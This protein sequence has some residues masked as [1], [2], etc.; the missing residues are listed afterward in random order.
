M[1]E[2][3]LKCPCYGKV[4][5]LIFLVNFCYLSA[6]ANSHGER[7]IEDVY[8]SLEVSSGIIEDV[9]IEV[10][11]KTGFNFHYSESTVGDQK[12][13]VKM[14]DVSLANCLR[15]ISKETGLSFK[16]INETIHVDKSENTKYDVLEE[17]GEEPK[18]DISVSGR[19]TGGGEGL[20]GVTVIVKGTQIGTVSDID[21]NYTIRVPS[22]ES[23]LVFSFVGFSTKEVVVGSQSEI[24]VSLE[25]DVTALE[26][27]VVIGYG[28]QKK[29]TVVGAVTQASSQVLERTAGIPNVATAL[30]G[31]LPGLITAASSGTPGDSNPRIVIRGNNTWNGTNSPLILVDGVERPEFF[32]NMDVASVAN[33]SV[34]KDASATAVFGSRGANG[35]I[36]VTTK[37][38]R[39]GKAEITANVNTTLKSVSKLPGTK[40]AYDAMQLRNRAIEYELA[41]NP[42]S[43]ADI[44]PQDIINKYRNPAN[45][46]EAER[47]PNIDWQDAL[48][49]DYAMAYNANVGIRG[50]TE[51][52]K[53]FA[54]IDFQNEQD[55]MRDYDNGRG[56]DPGFNYN[57]LNFRS[58]L[59]FQLTNST[60]LQT[61][62]GG[63]YGVRKTPWG[64]GQNDYGYWIAAYGN[65]PDAFIPRYSDGVWGFHAPNRQ[66]AL[67]SVRNL[68]ISG[69]ENRTTAT[70]STNFV[71]DQD[72]SMLVKGL[73]FKGTLALD[74][75]FIES[76]RGAN[77]LYN[78][79]QEKWINPETGVP[80][81][82]QAFDPSTRFDFYDQGAAWSPSAGSI[83]AFNGNAQYR[84]T[85]YQLQLNY[86]TSIVERHNITLMGLMNR[87]QEAYGSAV[88]QY[89][90]DWVFRTTYNFDGKYLLEYNGAYNGSEKFGKDYRFS[91]FSSGGIGWLISEENFMKSIGFLDYLKVRASYGEVGDDGGVPRFA[92]VDD[93]AYGEAAKLGVQGWRSEESPY[94]WYRQTNL[95]NPSVRWE[96]VYKYNL[97]LDFTFWN[98][99]IDG[100]VDFFRD[101]REDIFLSGGGRAVPSYFGAS[102]PAANLGKVTTEGFEIE[103]GSNYT[104]SSGVRIWADFAMTHAKDEV[105]LRDDPQ[106]LDDYQKQIGYQIGQSRTHV[107]SGYYNTW[108]DV[109]A[110]T[111]HNT[112]EASKL[113]G[114]YH[115]IDFNGDGLID[116]LD[117]IPYAFSSTPQNTFNTNIGVEWKGFSA[118]VQFYGVNNVT[119]QV[120]FN[121]LA[122]QLNRAYEEGSYWSKDNTNPDTPMPRWLSIVNGANSGSRYFY[123]GSFL[124]LKNA[125][126]AYRFESGWINKIG[127]Q[128]LRVYLN[129][130]NLLLWTKMPDDRESNFAGTGWAS[131]GAYPTVRR[132][133]LGLNMTF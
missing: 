116:N 131:Q 44:I 82:E 113:P 76:E 28:E 39:E 32:N 79:I 125:E 109:Y 80:F 99:I 6:K 56:Y 35:V 75:T 94:T 100:S 89:R 16:R 127:L 55:L 18:Q 106:L 49:Q 102:A 45:L 129:G 81:Y 110:S 63:S 38:G 128:S 23:V 95:G 7:S 51:V 126:I 86:Q 62:L 46:E 19:V 3:L 24:N 69:V 73:N 54:N 115:I 59:D 91:Y 111:R 98:G 41:T 9:F 88:P 133:S 70:I 71:L 53:Y 48:F 20:P 72:L 119:R 84:K 50:G 132:F 14:Q 5:F 29:E 83:S 47:Y 64:F 57:R 26:E 15:Q 52:T 90:E 8:L 124:R 130:N 118:F 114:N 60:K 34:L 66:A 107:S 27:V 22:R 68:A 1:K 37:R 120:V 2:F 13:T 58:N 36:I 12:L 92:F 87:M 4:V 121:S 105:L 123:D 11:T 103:L 17:L 85:F 117:V 25:D 97:A 43:W 77:D 112:N 108:D 31:N 61:N 101:K 65:S 40:D 122:G 104:F 42:D 21:G 74:N 93:W 78:A 67:N 96:T 33:I 30:T 10:G